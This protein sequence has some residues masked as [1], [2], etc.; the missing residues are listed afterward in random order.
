M[1]YTK[2]LF[3]G[4][5]FSIF[6]LSSC[7]KH[8]KDIIE[9]VNKDEVKDVVG[10]NKKLG[11]DIF[12]RTVQA[13]PDKNVLISAWSIQ[14]ALNMAVNGASGNTLDEM[15][16]TMGCAGCTVANINQEHELL[17]KFME[18]QSGSPI[19]TSANAF[20][21][22]QA[23]VN[24]LNPFLTTL[25]KSY[26]AT[27]A[28]YNFNNVDDSKGKI[29]AWVK[30]NTKGK[31]DGIIDAITDEDVAFLINAI[32]FK[33]DWMTGF[34]PEL[35]QDG[36]FITSSGAKA[37]AKYVFGDRTFNFG[38]D[39]TLNIVD[40]PFKDSTYSIS[41]VQQIDKNS[42]NAAW[43]TKITPDYMDLLY[44][45]LKQ[46]RAMVRFPRIKL[47]FKDD[48]VETLK[49]MGIKD[50]F[51][52]NQARF[53]NLSNDQIFINQIVHKAVLEIDEKGAEGA[54][55]SSI[56]FGNTSLPPVFTYDRPYVL[57]LRHIATNTMLFTGFVNDPSK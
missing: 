9:N 37:T 10:M 43:A 54:A 28:Q 32:Y 44:S 47:S 48:L 50:A 49:A 35:T 34:D 23:R 18:E 52:D 12:G 38:T 39:G 57:V 42:L 25:N 56:G 53:R 24:V 4:L 51:S 20:F 41:F 19:L 15:I 45:K 5:L 6:T 40:I 46:D 33:A 30:E 17:A 22:D 31:I 8:E 13:N 11:W 14:T 26:K 16:K 55:V 3:I 7:D 29:N 21:Y 27:N 2:F 1:T 36:D